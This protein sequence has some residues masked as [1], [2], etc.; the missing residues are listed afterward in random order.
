MKEHAIALSVALGCAMIA[1]RGVN[2]SAQRGQGRGGPP[3]T[4]RAAAPVDLTGYWVSVVTEDWRF[5]MVTPP[6]GDYASVPLN[7]E[8]RRIADAWDPS[9]DGVCDAYGAAAIMRLP[10]RLHITWQD[11]NTLKIETDAGQQ[12]RLLHFGAARPATGER[13]L[14][15]YSVAEW[16]RG[17]GPPGLGGFGGFGGNVAPPDAAAPAPAA[18]RGA[19]P[20]A[21]GRGAAPVAAAAPPPGRGPAPERW[22]PLKVVTTQLRPAWLRKNGIPYSENTVMTEYFDRHSAYGTEWFTVT[23]LVE[24]PTY[25]TQPFI[26][27]TH[28]KKE[29][30]GSKWSPSP[31]E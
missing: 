27:S 3:P 13:T 21:A 8:A 5:R 30:D 28:F 17:G 18:G 10:G 2:L 19:P 16:G 1:A 9:K 11:D 23:T 7:A 15:G 14:Q 26:T 4:P 25:L 6:K 24:D 31:C 22:A 20:P 12:T 29:A